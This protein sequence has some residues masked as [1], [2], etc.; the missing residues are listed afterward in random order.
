ML[1]FLLQGQ[2]RVQSRRQYSLSTLKGEWYCEQGL[3]SNEEINSQLSKHLQW[4]GTNQVK[5]RAAL[6]TKRSGKF[7]EEP[8]IL[9]KREFFIPAS[10]S[11]PMTVDI[12][13]VLK[14]KR[15]WF[16]RLG[17]TQKLFTNE[18]CQYVLNKLLKL[19]L[20][21][22]KEYVFHEAG[23]F[24][25]YDIYAKQKD[26]YFCAA[27]KTV[28]PLIYL[29]ELRA[30]LN[31]FGFA[32]QMLPA[33]QAAQS[34]LY[35]IFLRFGGHYHG[36]LT[37]LNAPYGIVPYLLFCLLIEFEIITVV[38]KQNCYSLHIKKANSEHI[39]E[40]MRICA[41]HAE[42]ELNAIEIKLSNPIDRAIAA[43]K[44]IK[45]RL[46]KKEFI[47]EYALIMDIKKDD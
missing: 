16:E 17:S 46:N 40:S 37:T 22:A 2:Y 30:D 33:E 41:K 29:E 10:H 24:I 32:A 36:M 4:L 3:V 38:R 31:A 13:D 25:G 5:L 14:S 23:H 39:I 12:V 20:I 28:W 19:E 44:Y 18:T 15:K 45:S 9:Y 47:K 35:N 27:G 7:H 1:S 8:D 42:I 43:A 6:I 26:N 21:I 34:F 11:E